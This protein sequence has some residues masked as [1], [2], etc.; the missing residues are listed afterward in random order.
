MITII[1][2]Y[3][4]DIDLSLPL[5]LFRPLG[6]SKNSLDVNHTRSLRLAGGEGGPLLLLLKQV[7]RVDDQQIHEKGELKRQLPVS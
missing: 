6:Q 5:L 1:H 2:R 7:K 4:N 3:K